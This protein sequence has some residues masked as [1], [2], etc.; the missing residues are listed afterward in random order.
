MESQ[1]FYPKAILEGPIFQAC[2]THTL[3]KPANKGLKCIHCHQI[4]GRLPK[5]KT[6]PIA[7]IGNAAIVNSQMI[8]FLSMEVTIR[9][10]K[11]V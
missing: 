8:L 11:K 6:I 7:F 3:S 2:F 10:T 5:S 1:Q 4:T 9:K